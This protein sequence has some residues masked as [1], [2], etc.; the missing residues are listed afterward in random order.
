MIRPEQPGDVSA[1]HELLRSTFPTEDEAQLV[2]ALRAAGRLPISIVAEEDGRIVGHIALSPV[3]VGELTGD[4]LG[5]AP[6]AVIPHRQRQGIGSRLV[7]AG[8]EA[9]AERNT[10]FVVVLGHPEYYP[11]FGFKRASAAG[12][13]NEY[14]ADEA[15]MVLEIRPGSM[16]AG[17]GLVKYAPEFNA[18]A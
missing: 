9:A 2:D 14:S 4:G 17:G 1:I 8:L 16:L 7:R 18:L 12:L 10:G 6:L 15:F 5:L 13:Q 3:T 11:R